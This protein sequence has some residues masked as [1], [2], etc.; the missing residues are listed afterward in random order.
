M[1]KGELPVPGAHHSP[2]DEK[3]NAVS[4]SLWFPS[5][6]MQLPEKYP[7][8]SQSSLSKEDSQVDSSA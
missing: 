4:G 2:N 7:Q 3:E 6:F 8:F 1:G 5:D